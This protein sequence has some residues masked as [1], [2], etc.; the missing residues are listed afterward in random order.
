MTDQAMT[1]A[2]FEEIQSSDDSEGINALKIR[3]AALEK[4]SK[5]FAGCRACK[6]SPNPETFYFKGKCKAGLINPLDRRETGK[7]L[8][9][10]DAWEFDEVRFSQV[11]GESV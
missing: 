5:K 2:Q 9:E 3:C 6:H 11:K 4:A 1:K 7:P 10:C 8:G